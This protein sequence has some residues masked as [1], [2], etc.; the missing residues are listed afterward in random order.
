MPGAASWPPAGEEA[1]DAEDWQGRVVD[2]DPV[3][4]L[5]QA[6]ARA[7]RGSLL[8]KPRVA[9][10]MRVGTYNVLGICGYPKDAAARELGGP[11]AAE[12]IG[13]FVDAFGQLETDILHLEEGVTLAMAQQLA[14]GMQ[15][16]VATFPSPMDWSANGLGQGCTGHVLSRFP[17]LESRTFSHHPPSTAGPTAAGT[18]RAGVGSGLADGGCVFSRCAGAALLDVGGGRTLWA[19]TVHLHPGDVP[20]REAEAALLAAKLPELLAVTPHVLVSGDFNS[21]VDEAVHV[22]LKKLGFVNALEAA[23]GGC[24]GQPT[25]DT[26]GIMPAVAQAGN[27]SNGGAIDHIYA[28]ASLAPRLRAARVVR[29]EGFRQEHT[30]PE[31][32]WA[33]S[34]HLPVVADFDVKFTAS[35]L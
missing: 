3:R 11:A 12:R 15:C 2:G 4:S 33:H 32:S 30:A 25:M 16:H 31:G 35:K 5:A 9:S 19:V 8:R 10:R 27:G 28:S 13:H 1:A 24:D 17:I 7:D 23:G 26:L 14:D 18:P 29:D 22:A 6:A 20:M 21:T 34:D